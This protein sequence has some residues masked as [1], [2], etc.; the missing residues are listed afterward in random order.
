MFTP[1]EYKCVCPRCGVPHVIV[2]EFL[3]TE[4]AECNDGVTRCGYLC[5]ECRSL[6][7]ENEA[8]RQEYRADWK[9]GA[10]YHWSKYLRVNAVL[11]APILETCELCGGKMPPKFTIAHELCKALKRLGKPTPK[12]D[13]KL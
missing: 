1:K 8:L 12:L 4:L 13:F 6:M 11:S 5:T 9:R 7:K 10:V 3:S 2:S